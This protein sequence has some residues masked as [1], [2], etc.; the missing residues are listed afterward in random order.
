[1]QFQDNES[2]KIPNIKDTPYT[3]FIPQL[4]LKFLI[5]NN[6]MVSEDYREEFSKKFLE[7]IKNKKF[8]RILTIWF[9]E[10]VMIPI[11]KFLSEYSNEQYVL[12]KNGSSDILN[13]TNIEN[14]KLSEMISN[15]IS[16]PEDI[17]DGIVIPVY[18]K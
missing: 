9:S 2:G 16:A 1:M 13:G 6:I 8:N 12:P 17:F 15:H 10:Y 3:N 14:V 18:K 5:N 7:K 11:L 4:L